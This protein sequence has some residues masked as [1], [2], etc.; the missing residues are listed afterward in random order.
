MVGINPL[1]FL[2]EVQ[3]AYMI[4]TFGEVISYDEIYSDDSFFDFLQREYNFKCDDREQLMKSLREMRCEG[5][6]SRYENP[7]YYKFFAD[8]ICRIHSIKDTFLDCDK[9]N[10]PLFGTIE[11]DMF[12]AQIRCPESNMPSIILFYSG[13]IQFAH[14]ITNV[15]TKAFP[16]QALDEGK[17][18]FI[19]EPKKIK[20]CVRSNKW[21]EKRFTDIVLS[22]FFY[23]NVDMCEVSQPENDYLYRQFSNSLADSFL[24]FITAHECAHY[25]LGH[26]EKDA[27]KEIVT[28]ETV[29][30]ESIVPNWEQEFDADYIGALLT[31]P[32][33]M[34]KGMDV[35]VILGGIYVAMWM[36][37]IIESLRIKE[38][39]GRTT[40]PLAKDRLLQIKGK[41]QRI[42]QDDLR[43]LEVYDVLFST[44]WE[45]FT[46][47]AKD[48][49]DRII[50]G[51]SASEVT[52]EQIKQAIYC[53]RE[54]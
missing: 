52:Y 18:T 49:D 23:G 9:P 21:I 54:F 20:E 5:V 36:L 30:Y 28:V 44:L 48:I 25:Y 16:I 1:E 29:Q 53:E 24:T 2:E 14:D 3:R 17:I 4:S 50:K 13:I 45:R 19:M 31:I 40:H 38:E 12:Y 6:V 42:M 47:I 34:E 32:V 35:Q 22:I 51:C 7:Y 27:A 26:L 10:M 33:L 37:S 8:I 41:L 46:I 43:V 39:T 15:L 11:F